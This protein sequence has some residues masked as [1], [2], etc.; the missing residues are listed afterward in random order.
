MSSILVVEDD[1]DIRELLVDIL[2]CEGYEAQGAM[3]GREALEQLERGLRPDLIIL[4]LMMPVM[5]GWALQEALAGSAEWKHIP[6]VVLSASLPPR[7]PE[8]FHHFLPKPVDLDR[9]H[10]VLGAHL[11]QRAEPRAS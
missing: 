9:L 2:R 1:P 3:H 4:D 10:K 11:G 8:A 5:N 7:S 6:I